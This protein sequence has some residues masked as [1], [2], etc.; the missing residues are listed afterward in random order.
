[1]MGKT[2][3]AA[4]VGCAG[5]NGTNRETDSTAPELIVAVAISIGALM[6]RNRAHPHAMS[7]L[8][9]CSSSGN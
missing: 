5:D 9:Q 6:S 2:A 4:R 1:M 8:P 7:P 3:A